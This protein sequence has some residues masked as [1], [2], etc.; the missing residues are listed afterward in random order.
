MKRYYG[1]CPNCGGQIEL[2]A[3]GKYYCESCGTAYAPDLDRQEVEEEKKAAEPRLQK[4]AEEL[5]KRLQQDKQ[6]L[7]GQSAARKQQEAANWKRGDKISKALLFGFIGFIIIAFVL[8]A[9]ASSIL[10]AIGTSKSYKTAQE[11][12]VDLALSFKAIKDYDQIRSDAEKLVLKGEDGYSLN[13]AELVD[14]YV[15]SPVTTQVDRNSLL[16]FYTM[17]LFTEARAGTVL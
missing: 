4:Q 5:D 1:D 16:L 12:K 13:K 10:P 14:A 11:N 7:S 6:I 8:M 9:F 15:I 2:A 17:L 3:D